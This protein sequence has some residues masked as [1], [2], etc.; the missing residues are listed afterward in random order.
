MNKRIN[1]EDI[2]RKHSFQGNKY[3]GN[4]GPFPMTSYSNN[5]SLNNSFVNT[6]SNP[7]YMNSFIP[8]VQINENYRKS[9][10]PLNF[11][12]CKAIDSFPF[13]R[14]FINNIDSFSTNST[15]PENTY[16]QNKKNSF[17]SSYYNRNMMMNSLMNQ[18][19]VRNCMNGVDPNIPNTKKN[20]A[21]NLSVSNPNMNVNVPKNNMNNHNNMN[22]FT[23][24][25]SS[26]DRHKENKIED[27]KAFIKSKK[28]GILE[29]IC[30][31]RGAKETEKML[32][33]NTI[34]CIS[35]LL[36]EI[37]NSFK[38]VMT[39]IYGNYFIQK[40]IKV[41]NQEQIRFILINIKNDFVD[42]AKDFS[43]THVLQA[44][45]TLITKPEDQQ[46]LLGII[47][48]HEM[49]LAL[50][51]NATHV[52]QKIIEVVSEESRPELNQII[53]DNFKDLCLNSNGICLIKKFIS[54]NKKTNQISKIM[55]MKFLEN[56]M[57]ISQNP[58]GNY[59]IQFIL[60]QWDMNFLQEIIRF[61]IDNCLFLSKQ[62]FS[63]NVIEKI[64]EI[65]NPE[66]RTKVFST[67]FAEN[68]LL[69]LLKNKYGKYVL[70]RSLKNMNEEHK[71]TLQSNF[72][73]LIQK[74]NMNS[75]EKKLVNNFLKAFLK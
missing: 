72:N 30:S 12:Y 17:T 34:E 48:G 46:F 5:I 24:K 49:E 62:K 51:N 2:L 35:I 8:Q 6:N 25:L 15:N 42:V 37:K 64:I 31:Q 3:N 58:F 33:K 57:E 16:L 60:E 56:G 40:I 59:A 39:N 45:I 7:Y 63:S 32:K 10:H 74:N 54:K 29:T 55:K 26:E 70:Q 4:L 65:G 36:E 21:S 20:S 9:S 14:P 66:L 1:D 28:N 50:D 41:S 27:F 18:I 52:L 75:K 11:D 19:N 71:N 38:V 53:L 69:P 68:R 13:S 43:G 61:V 44:L 47:K 67:L 22:N 73:N 23:V